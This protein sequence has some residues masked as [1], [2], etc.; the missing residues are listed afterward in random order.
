MVREPG[1]RL[2]QLQP[3]SQQGA[4]SMRLERLHVHRPIPA[5][6]HDLS[7]TLGI[8]P[9]VLVDL[10]L[11]RCTRMPGIEAD[12]RKRPVAQ[13][14]HQPRPGLNS[15]SRIYPGMSAKDGR[16]LIRHRAALA[17]PDSLTCLID[18]ADCRG[19]LGDIQSN[20]KGHRVAPIGLKPGE[21]RPDR[22]TIGHPAIRDYRM[23]IH[24]TDCQF[25]AT[26]RHIGYQG[27]SGRSS[28]AARADL[29]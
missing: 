2:D 27:T 10:H 14:M 9:V 15:D 29:G 19:L 23:S 25:A 26:Q 16:N 17:A 21:N 4:S 3:R 5:R 1:R 28:C 20:V 6:A 22:G 13:L 7:A 12:N 8:I 11:Q 24:G 18:D